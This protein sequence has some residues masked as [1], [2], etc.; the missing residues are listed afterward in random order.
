MIMAYKNTFIEIESPYCDK[1]TAA[2]AVV[3]VE[4]DQTSTWIKGADKGP[5]AIIEASVSIELYDIET[6]S[7]PY[8]NGIFIDEP[9]TG[10]VEPEKMVS[11]VYRR[12]SS[13]LAQ[14]KLVVTLGG[15]HSVSVGSIIAHSEKYPNLSV[16]QLDAHADLRP[17]YHGSKFNHACVM[18]RAIEMAQIVQVGIRSMDECEL[19]GLDQGRVFFAENIYSNDTWIDQAIGKLTDNVYLTIDLD[20]FDPSILPS[21]GTPEP[22]G[23]GWYQVLKLIR[24]LTEQK[25][26]VGFDIVELCPNENAKASDLLAAKLLYKILAYKFISS[27]I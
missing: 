12:V 3:P 23:L 13:L 16:L 9:I 4:Y 5:G 17:E 6:K 11:D 24:R 8:V 20:V 2:V 27:K 7:L 21:T 25:R 15:E 10:I 14:D 18:A 19:A 1:E 26:L 22:G